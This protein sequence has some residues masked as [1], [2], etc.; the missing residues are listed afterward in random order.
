MRGR[1]L[2]THTERMTLTDKIQK[3]FAAALSSPD[4]VITNGAAMTKHRGTSP[5]RER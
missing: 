5:V 3:E 1:L 4:V 2:P